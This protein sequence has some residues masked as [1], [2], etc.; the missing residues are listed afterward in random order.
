MGEYKKALSFYKKALII[1]QKT[2]GENHP[3]TANFYMNIGLVYETKGEYSKALNY[4]EKSLTI[5]IKILGKE[6]PSTAVS[7]SNIATLYQKMGKYPKALNL[8]NK[9]LNIFKKQLGEKHIYTATTYN[10]LASLHLIIDNYSKALMYYKKALAIDI[11][12]LG[13]EHIDTAQCYNNIGGVYYKLGNYPEA[14]NYFKKALLIRENTLGKEHIDTAQSYNNIGLIYSITQKPSE[15]LDYYQKSLAIDRKNLGEEHSKTAINYNNIGGIYS[16]MGNYQKAL[17]YYTKALS[18]REKVL[19]AKHPDIAQSYHNIAS[20][21]EDFKSYS[22]ALNYYQKSLII[23]KKILGKEHSTVASTYNNISR[24]YENKKDYAKAYDYAK[25]SFDIFIKN[26]DKNFQALTN[27]E[28]NIYL[29][30]NKYIASLLFRVAN[31]LKENNQIVNKEVLNSWLNYKG[32]I[33]DSENSIS[34]LYANTKDESLKE[35]IEDLTAFKRGLAKLYQSIPKSKEREVWK[36]KIEETENRIAMLTNDITQKASSFKEQQGLTHISYKEI[37]KNLKEHELYID[38]AKAGKYY[39]LFTLD[40]KEH[41]TFTQIDKEDSQKINELVILFKRD[42]QNILNNKKSNQLTSNSKKKLFELYKLAIFKPLGN[43]FDSKKSLIIS[44]DGVLRL[45]PFEALYDGQ[46]YLIESKKIKYIPSGKEL[47]RLYRYSQNNQ[48]NKQSIVFA[49]PNFDSNQSASFHKEQIALTRGTNE[50]IIKPFFKESYSPLLGT[51]AEAK[52]IDRL[53]DNIEIFEGN[54]ANETNLLAVKEPKILHIATHGFFINTPNIPN[55]ML[56][57]GIV[58]SGVNHYAKRKQGYGRV[59][60]LKLSGLN[61]RSTDLVVLSACETGVVDV[62]DT[63]SISGLGKAFIQ[64]G[65]KDVV[66]SLWSVDDNATKEL[67]IDFY[68]GIKKHSNYSRALRE[69]KLKMIDEGR[70]PFYW[71]GFVLNGL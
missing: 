60:A 14:L 13:K 30:S 62:N 39:Y 38:Y 34:T 4:H 63:D 71:G 66:M 20:T 11:R 22:K 31:T 54:R 49:N 57:S 3:N 29:K 21:Y 16:D 23:S 18:I 35:K 65:A 69:A 41:I 46:K 19:D 25:K 59:T 17:E 33:F 55:P 44:P 5:K 61:L 67:M 40:N 8:L 70:H 51:E 2:L 26:Q 64:A 9:V 68:R 1:N 28:K 27:K 42:I 36:T 45:L 56:K 37:A 48:S 7:Y 43:L 6:H 32:S 58:L 52:E 15:A 50:N 10:N 47:V 12:V 53:M 24:L